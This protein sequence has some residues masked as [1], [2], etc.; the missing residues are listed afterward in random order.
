[1]FNRSLYFLLFIF[2]LNVHAGHDDANHYR[3]KAYVAVRKLPHPKYQK[4][5]RRILKLAERVVDEEAKNELYFEV[6]RTLR[7]FFDIKG[8]HQ[9]DFLDKQTVLLHKSVS[10]IITFQDH[11]EMVYQNNVKKPHYFL[12]LKEK[13]YGVFKTRTPA[14][15]EMACWDLSHFFGC[16]EHI[17]PTL[18]L[19]FRGELASYQPFI[20]AKVSNFS[21]YRPPKYHTRVDSL[22]FWKTN[23]FV[24]ILGLRDLVPP[25]IPISKSGNLI[26]YDTE[27]VFV[28][29][30]QVKKYKKSI[31]LPFV[32]FMITWPQA[33]KG[34]SARE[35]RR[36]N[37]FV[38]HWNEEDLDAYLSHPLT[39]LQ[40]SNRAY[41]ALME[42]IQILK[43]FG[44]FE[45]NQ[46]F[47]ELFLYFYPEFYKGVEEILPL[48]QRITKCP[49]SPYTALY[50]IS[51]PDSYWKNLSP[52]DCQRLLDWVEKYY[53]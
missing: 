42:R 43:D 11:E 49:L 53:E 21:L 35:A 46:T 33:K 13:Q 6:V 31:K 30:N 38:T 1:M 17:A 8:F 22:T 51:H 2:C 40:L 9:K 44:R 19:T 7:Y 20:N 10:T 29:F 45:E 36:L 25:N 41:T 52:V 18:T 4:R 3:N 16:S 15:R 28:P 50:F 27:A 26:L 34:L 5:L 39:K 14:Y 12:A 37:Q 48:I 47:E 23:L 32:N 24:L